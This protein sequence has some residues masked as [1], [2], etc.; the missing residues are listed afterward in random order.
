MG[1]WPSEL[2]KLQALALAILA[3]DISPSPDLLS[4]SKSQSSY[5]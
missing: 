4:H 1:Q 2:N 3:K 5:V